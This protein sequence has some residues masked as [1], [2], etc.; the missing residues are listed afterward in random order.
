MN[1]CRKNKRSIAWMAAGVL[2]VT[3]A[4]TLRQHMEDCAA[5]RRYWQSMCELSERLAS[6]S[7]LPTAE[8]TE[9]FHRTVVQKI[10]KQAQ[11]ARFFDWMITVQR[12]CRELPLATF[13][14]GAVVMLALLLWINN[15]GRD[16]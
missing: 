8:P 12:L 6:A 2:D 9:R 1:P 11:H 5:C 7:N 10:R 15:S 13:S 3:D 16:A 14:A 4:E